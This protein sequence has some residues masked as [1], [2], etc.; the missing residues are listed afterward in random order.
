MKKAFIKQ[1]GSQL[2]LRL[3]IA[4]WQTL[5]PCSSERRFGAGDTS[6]DGLERNYRNPPNSKSNICCG[7][8]RSQNGQT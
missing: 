7:K 4:E 8:W 5:V 6:K 1:H 2:T 3:S